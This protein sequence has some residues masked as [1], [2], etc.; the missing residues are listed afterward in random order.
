MRKFTFAK[1]SPGG[2]STILIREP[3][4]AGEEHLQLAQKLLDPLHLQAEQVGFVNLKATPPS[5]DMMAG[6]FCL[7]ATRSLVLLMFM[8]KKFL[9]IAGTDDLFGL[10]RCS[11]QNGPLEARVKNGKNAP[12]DS[13]AAECYVSLRVKLDE[14]TIREEERGVTLVKLPGIAHVL[15]DEELHPAPLDMMEAAAALRA[16][17]ALESEAASGVVWYK[18]NGALVRLHAESEVPA[19]LFGITPLVHITA[20]NSSTLESSCGSASLALALR[21]AEVGKIKFFNIAQPCGAHLH[22]KL[23]WAEREE[24][25]CTVETGG[26]VKM[27]AS[28]HTYI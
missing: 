21:H 1:I 2:N 11:G 22:L 3:Q 14:N 19:S 27:I 23:T 24:D 8:E 7:N 13:A 28:G 17:Y 12:P 4:T 18:K 25:G 9:P 15:L 10:V 5:L 20:S 16:K 26:L 6:E